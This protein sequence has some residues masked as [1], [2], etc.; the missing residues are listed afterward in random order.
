M[1]DK[2]RILEYM[3]ENGSITRAEAWNA[4]GCA[5]VTARISELKK[6]GHP[7]GTVWETG[8]DRHGEKTRWGR[9]VLEEEKNATV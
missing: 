4:F 8:L 7:I 9:W 6:L 3:R 2:E 1:S 5:N